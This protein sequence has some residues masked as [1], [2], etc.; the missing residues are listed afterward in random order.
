MLALCLWLAVGCS[1]VF[2][3]GRA[4]PR[5]PGGALVVAVEPEPTLAPT[6]TP[7]PPPADPAPTST[8]TVRPRQTA[9]FNR[10]VVQTTPT[11]AV[12]ATEAGQFSGLRA[13]RDVE[14]LAD[15]IGS[16]VAGG[17]AVARAAEYLKSQ[18]EAAG[19]VAELRP[20]QFSAFQD[21]GSSLEI[22]GLDPAAVDVQTLAYSGAGDPRAE[23]IDVG[24]ARE[25]DFS[26]AQ[27]RGKIALAERGEI[28]FVD[29]A[30]NLVA[31]GATGLVI[32]NNQPGTFVGSLGRQ[33]G[34]PVVALSQEAGQ[35]LRARLT[36]GPVAAHLRVDAG[37]SEQTGHNVVASRP[38]GSRTVIIGAHYDSVSAGP[39][40]NDNASG[41]ATV[42]ELARVIAGRSYPFTVEF[43]AFGAEELGLIGSSRY[44]DALREA[45]RRAVLAMIN[46]DMVGVGDRLSFGGDSALVE[47]ALRAAGELGQS[48]GRMRSNLSSS[49]DHASFQA[50]SIPALFVYRGEDPNYHTAG[51]L[52]R[53]VEAEH[54]EAA[55]R[56]VLAVLDE[57]AEQP[58]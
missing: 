5:S 19:L 23:L 25:G 14:Q 15:R 28:R 16:R 57:L 3:G 21:R 29:K 38:G 26:P 4:E 12:V 9:A 46:L 13:R 33:V 58:R 8:A 39:G 35:Q 53:Y 47:P 40:A 18:F 11:P 56:V 30:A 49:S 24:L 27:V 48:A 6:S 44:V 31:A 37:S 17:P 54:L 51:D 42:L 43:V 50:A 32:F 1:P 34:L 2:P 20:F 52:T 10:S 55:G 45:D 41:T 7:I 36:A 22:D